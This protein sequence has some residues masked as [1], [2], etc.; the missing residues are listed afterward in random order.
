MF[1]LGKENTQEDVNYVIGLMPDIVR[2]LRA[3]SPL[4]PKELKE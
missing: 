2:R 1:T 3:I 4:T